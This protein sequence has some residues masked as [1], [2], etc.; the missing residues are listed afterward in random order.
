MGKNNNP[1]PH[2]PFQLHQRFRH[3]PRDL[4]NLLKDP[5]NKH[6]LYLQLRRDVLN[7]RYRMSVNGHLSAAAMALQV[8][9][10]DYSDDVHG[11]SDYFLLEHYLPPHVVDKLGIT[12]TKTCLEKLH[13]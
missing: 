12:E 1:W 7:G 10:G 8:E 9:F 6:Q 5:R 13:R 2:P 4:C 11:A 3:L